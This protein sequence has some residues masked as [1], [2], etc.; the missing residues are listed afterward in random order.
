MKFVTIVP[1]LVATSACA[2]QPAPYSPP[3]IAISGALLAQAAGPEGVVDITHPLSAYDLASIAIMSNPDLKVVRAQEGLAGAQLFAAGLLPDPTLSLGADFPIN[4][5]NTVIALTSSLG[6]DLAALSTRPARVDAAKA[7]AAS[8]RQDVLWTEWL[9]RQNAKLLATRISWLEGI[10]LKTTSYRQ[11]AD[12]DLDRAIAAA[13]RGDIAAIEVD[14][15][16]LAAA[17]A[18]DRDRSAENQLAAARLDLN[19]L[20]GI[21]PDEIIRLQAPSATEADMP[22]AESLFRTA[23]DARADLQGLREGLAAANAGRAVADASRFP[24]PGISLNAGRDTGNLRTLGPAV[25][26]TLPVWNRARGDQAVAQTNLQVLEAQYQARAETVRADI[27]AA[28]T[29]VS[30]ARRQRADVVQ[31]LAGISDQADR[32]EIAA[33]RGDVSETSAAATR[34]AALDKEILADSLALAA[35]ESAIALETA[36]GRP[37]DVFE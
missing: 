33:R 26:F 8:V 34:L 35:A 10:K 15:R 27:G 18:S 5:V 2:T 31:D 11:I 36:I 25:S 22:A 23:L 13:A 14:A 7:N 21:A 20:L 17:D 9:T 3:D 6:L 37:M 28:L 29:A 1:M 16:R 30:I 32:A 24:L 12:Q 19:R 4:G